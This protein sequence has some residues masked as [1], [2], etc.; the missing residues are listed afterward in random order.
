[1]WVAAG[2]GLG[3]FSGGV[4]GFFS[5]GL[6][7]AGGCLEVVVVAGGFVSTLDSFIYTKNISF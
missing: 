2:V 3:A 7:G 4:A 6:V 1:M 5:A